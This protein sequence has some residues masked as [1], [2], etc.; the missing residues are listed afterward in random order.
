MKTQTLFFILVSFFVVISGQTTT[1]EVSTTNSPTTVAPTTAEPTTAVPTTTAAPTTAASTT[2]AAT[3][4]ASTTAAPTSTAAPT[5]VAPTTAAPTTLAQKVETDYD[6]GT[7]ILS[8]SLS[9]FGTLF[10]IAL[11]YF[12]RHGISNSN[13]TTE[14][15]PLMSRQIRRDF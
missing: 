12:M 7:L 3:T 9:L 4:E 11:V 10:V 15:V 5:T 1:T 8:M 2:V 13:R 6:V 14:I